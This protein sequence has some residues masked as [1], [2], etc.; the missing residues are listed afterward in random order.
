MHFVPWWTGGEACSD[1]DEV[2]DASDANDVSVELGG[3]RRGSADRA[4]SSVGSVGSVGVGGVLSFDAF[5]S[6]MAPYSCFFFVFSH[7]STLLHWFLMD[8]FVGKSVFYFVFRRFIFTSIR[9]IKEEP[10][11]INDLNEIRHRNRNGK[12]N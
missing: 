3:V 9:S 6:S 2:S 5:L 1:A 4:G 11:E 7:Q 12:F 8:I 10:S